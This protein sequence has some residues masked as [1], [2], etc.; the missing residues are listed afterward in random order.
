MGTLL[1]KYQ[2]HEAS[3][4]IFKNRIIRPEM[5]ASVIIMLQ[6]VRFDRQ[7]SYLLKRQYLHCQ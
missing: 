4:Q 5:K 1:H 3:T 6:K 7:T 2:V